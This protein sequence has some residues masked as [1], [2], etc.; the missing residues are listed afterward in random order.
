MDEVVED[1]NVP[2]VM[3]PIIVKQDSLDMLIDSEDKN[4]YG[5]E[6]EHDGKPND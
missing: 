1:E 3:E 5:D 6:V 2:F 4:E